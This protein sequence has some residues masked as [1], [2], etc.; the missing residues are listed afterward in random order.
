M[1]NSCSC[2]SSGGPPS[3]ALLH[4]L[5]F[6]VFSLI[7][8]VVVALA[9]IYTDLGQAKRMHTPKKPVNAMSANELAVTAMQQE[10][11]V[12]LHA[13]AWN[14]LPVSGVAT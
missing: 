1:P 10:T 4:H 3:A 2:S 7:S 13:W 6:D 14:C 8:E 9:T 12:L 5:R 11:K